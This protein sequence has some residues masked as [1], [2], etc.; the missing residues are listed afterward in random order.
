M[1]TLNSAPQEFTNWIKQSWSQL[2]D[3][4]MGVKDALV[5]TLDSVG[6]RIK[7]AYGKSYGEALTQQ[8]AQNRARLESNRQKITQWWIFSKAYNAAKYATNGTLWRAYALGAGWVVWSVKAVPQII[9]QWSGV[10]VDWVRWSIKAWGNIVGWLVSATWE[11]LTGSG[12]SISK[13]TDITRKSDDYAQ[14]AIKS[15]ADK[16]SNKIESQ[17][18]Q[19]WIQ[20]TSEDKSGQDRPTI[21]LNSQQEKQMTKSA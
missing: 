18:D 3:S 8:F 14:N 17:Q 10:L 20:K 19:S 12:K 21:P 16:V 2:F 7:T 5:E 15:T 1:S 13:W 6:N 9:W 4:G 11:L